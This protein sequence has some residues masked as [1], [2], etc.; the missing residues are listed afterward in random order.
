M[1]DTGWSVLLSVNAS[2]LETMY[3]EF[4]LLFYA[5]NK[6]KQSCTDELIVMR[7]KKGWI[8]ENLYSGLLSTASPDKSNLIFFLF[9]QFVNNAFEKLTGYMASDVVGTEI[10]T[11]LQVDNCNEEETLIYHMK[12]Y[13]VS[14]CVLYNTGISRIKSYSEIEVYSEKLCT[15]VG[16]NH[17]LKKFEPHVLYKKEELVS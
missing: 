3:R 4:D 17:R 2:S 8:C 14:V 6:I 5:R 11:K 7:N 10:Q 12:K 13:Q 16:C 1:H 9:L 15:H